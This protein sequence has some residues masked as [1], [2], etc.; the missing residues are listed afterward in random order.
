MTNLYINGQLV[1]LP[2]DFKITL[3]TENLYFSKASTY[4]YDIKLS[5]APYSN[6]AKIFGNL[7]RF[8]KTLST[9]S[10][11]ARLIVDNKVIINGTAVV[12]GITDNSISVQLL[13][14]RSEENWKNKY[15]KVY[16]DELDLGDI[17]QWGL[18]WEDGKAQIDGSKVTPTEVGTQ[19]TV[20]HGFY[21]TQKNY[22]DYTNG[23][24]VLTPIINHDTGEIMNPIG[25]ADEFTTRLV[26]CLRDPNVFWPTGHPYYILPARIAPQPKL[27]IMVSKIFEAL[28]LN[29]VLNELENITFYNKIIMANSTEVQYIADILPHITFI[30]FVELMQNLF[31]CIIDIDGVNTK[32]YM[33]KNI[34]AE[35]GKWGENIKEVVDEFETEIDNEKSVSDS[36]KAK[37][38]DIA[39]PDY[40]VEF[41]GDDFKNVPIITDAS[42]LSNVGN[43]YVFGRNVARNIKVSSPYAYNNQ[44]Y[45]NA[46]DRWEPSNDLEEKVTLKFVPLMN[47]QEKKID[48][49]HYFY[50]QDGN[51]EITGHLYADIVINIPEAFGHNTQNDGQNIQELLDTYDTPEGRITIDKLCLGFLS[52]NFAFSEPPTLGTHDSTYDILTSMFK[53]KLESQL[54]PGAYIIDSEQL[55]DMTLRKRLYTTLNPVQN[56]Y[57]LFYKD[58]TEIETSKIVNISFVPKRK[59]FNVL[60]SFLI[61]NLIFACK[62]IKYTI[63]ANGFEKIAEGEFYK[64]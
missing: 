59:I 14:G 50:I 64:I 1:D 55:Y 46:I 20:N 7:N 51:F 18:K 62:Q 23:N 30:E 26:F 15:E 16:I 58:T 12:V 57:H 29:V 2:T 40:G 19:S 42:K 45:G 4:T 60:H 48:E 22:S 38:Y 17:S 33:R 32:I 34:Y 56:F 3:V 24:V 36:D 37:V 47:F 8:D 11:P 5:M 9:R 52:K 49:H 10:W 53:A 43:P 63:S 13:Q 27:K 31:N 61:K 44:I 35:S 6:N 39:Y 21:W 54:N 25:S 28:G 41:L